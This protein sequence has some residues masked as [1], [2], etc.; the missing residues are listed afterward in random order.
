MAQACHLAARWLRKASAGI[1]HVVFLAAV[2]S[3]AF[4][5]GGSGRHNVHGTPY[6][7]TATASAIQQGQ[8]LTC[9]NEL[10]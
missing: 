9:Q 10:L 5:E 3:A 2:A 4:P 7:T 8:A 6:N 1:Y